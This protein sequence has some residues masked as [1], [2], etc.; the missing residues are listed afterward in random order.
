MG[1]PIL[2]SA[3][4]VDF[5]VRE[6]E[7][8]GDTNARPGR[9]KRHKFETPAV[10]MI[11]SDLIGFGLAFSLAAF[12]TPFAQQ[13]LG[14]TPDAPLHLLSSR[15]LE[16][17][18]FSVLLTAVFAFGGLY[19]RACWE[20]EELGKIVQGVI[21]L[22]LFDA[23]LQYLLKEPSSRLWFLAAW[24]IVGLFVAGGRMIVRTIPIIREAMSSH[25]LLIGAGV[26]AEAFAHD[27]RESRSGTVHVLQDLPIQALAALGKDALAHRFSQLARAHGRE[28]HQIQIVVAPALDETPAAQKL[29]ENLG[30]ISRP[31]SVVLPYEGLASSGLRLRSVVGADLVLAEVANSKTTNLNKTAKRIFDIAI[32][33]IMLA[34]LSPMLLLISI[35]LR[36]EGAPILFSQ[37]R[38]S[39][40]G[41]RFDCYKFRSMRPDAEKRLLEMLSRSPEARNEWNRHQKLENDPRIT[42]LGRFIRMTSLDEVPQLINIL[43]GDMSLVGPRPIIAPEVPGYPSDKAYFDSAGFAYY[44]D[45]LPGITGLWQVSGRTQTTHN[46]RIR[47]DRWYARNR[48]FSLDLIILFKTVREVLGCN[49][50]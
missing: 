38:I 33:L 11:L 1:K 9:Q 25:F 4:F 21:L 29:I 16:L 8:P 12:L 48:S 41:R 35:L 47:L 32:S 28:I 7:N 45:C 46:E 27:A 15:Q 10:A 13:L 24:P 44:A 20:S 36:L 6:I 22:A 50:R 23:A 30:Q 31:F 5:P 37:V 39:R 40:G 2:S 17:V 3:Q 49:G 19:Q 14:N 26:S 42:P 43:K 18:L 34:F